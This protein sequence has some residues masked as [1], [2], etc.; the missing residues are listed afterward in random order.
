MHTGHSKILQMN[1]RID[2]NE[3][4]RPQRQFHSKDDR[5]KGPY[6]WLDEKDPRRYMTDK[7]ILES[8]IDLSEACI[9][10]KQEKDL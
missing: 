8:A 10:E 2:I 4:Q 7:E 1:I 6:P 3:T 5:D 9:T